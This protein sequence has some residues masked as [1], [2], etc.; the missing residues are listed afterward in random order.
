MSVAYVNSWTPVTQNA[1]SVNIPITGVS[2]GDLL[3][4]FGLNG[5]EPSVTTFTWSD[6]SG[7]GTFNVL[8]PPGHYNDGDFDAFELN[9]YANVSAGA[10][11]TTLASNGA[12]PFMALWIAEY[13]G[14]ISFSSVAGKRVV[15]PG[16][17][18][19][20]IQG[21]SV[22]LNSGDI[23]VGLCLDT[24]S[25]TNAITVGTNGNSR[26][27]LAT[28]AVSYSFAD[29]SGPGSVVPQWTSAFG[30]SDSFTVL[31]MT[32]SSVV[33]N[34]ATIAWIV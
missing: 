6:P 4:L 32:L 23:V 15:T 8:N 2:G 9:A 28:G 5:N 24:S 7:S 13:S 10:H 34:S 33:T 27:T 17:G 12:S 26:Q 16:N 11:N 21:T 22:T 3:A 20:A 31:Q 30:T 18:A 25:G 19:N 29:W 14:V 1:S